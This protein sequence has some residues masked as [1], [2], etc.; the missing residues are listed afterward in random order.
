MLKNTMEKDPTKSSED[1]LMLLYQHLR[2]GEAP[3]IDVASK[4]IEKN[5]IFNP[6]GIP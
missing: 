2:T 6:S 5:G 3:T 1:A 4:F